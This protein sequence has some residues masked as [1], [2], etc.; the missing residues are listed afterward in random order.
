MSI[1]FNGS[2]KETPHTRFLQMYL[3]HFSDHQ[4]NFK[5]AEREWI[6]K[7]LRVILLSKLG[8]MWK[9][10]PL[11]YIITE[12]LLTTFI[13]KLQVTFHLPIH[14]PDYC[15]TCWIKC[16]IWHKTHYHTNS[17]TWWWKCDGLVFVASGPG[18]LA[19]TDCNYQLFTST[20]K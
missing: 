1:Q 8:A 3:S 11:C 4:T 19:V 12:L 17:E 5:V 15:Q 6:N 7:V 14:G 18:W 20:K 9:S 13:E 16:Y 10:T 2:K